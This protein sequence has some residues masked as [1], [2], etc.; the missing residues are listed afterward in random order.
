MLNLCYVITCLNKCIRGVVF[1]G[2]PPATFEVDLE[3]IDEL[4]VESL[5]GVGGGGV[6]GVHPFLHEL[7]DRGVV[8]ELHY[9]HRNFTSTK[10]QNNSG[11]K[12][13]THQQ[14]AK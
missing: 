2:L 6:V 9:R 11:E 13:Q 3:L 14:S 4:S 8:H 1:V 7:V 10:V 12:Q 5:I